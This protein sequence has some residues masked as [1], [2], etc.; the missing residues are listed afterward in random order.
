MPL[1]A[2]VNRQAQ[3]ARPLGF[4]W[5]A[6]AWAVKQ[7]NGYDEGFA[8]G[9]WYDDDDFFFRLWQ[10]GLDFVFTDDISGSHIHHERK[11]LDTKEG[12]AGIQRN[13][14]HMLTKHQV[15]D[16]WHTVA[17]TEERRPGR[18]TWRHL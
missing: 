17:R 10:T 2:V 16:L 9:F 15:L 1:L 14:D 18:T 3:G 13:R 4:I 5:A 8:D 7:I 11:T 12:Y 6:P